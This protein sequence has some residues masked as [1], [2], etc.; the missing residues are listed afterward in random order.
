VTIAS[1]PLRD[2]EA[3]IELIAAFLNR[4][5]SYVPPGG[6]RHTRSS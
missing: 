5:Y 1:A 2:R 6:L 3:D 4:K